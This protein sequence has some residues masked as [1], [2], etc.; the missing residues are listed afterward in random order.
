MPLFQ[1]RKADLLKTASTGGLL[2]LALTFLPGTMQAGTISYDLLLTPGSGSLYGGTGVVTIDTAPSP[3]T[4]ST[5]TQANGSLQS[6]S[7]YI[8]G[9]TFSLAGAS[10]SLVQFTD[11]TLTDI[12][13]SEQ[14]GA[15]PLR[16]DL[17][18]SGV[19]AFYYNNELSRSDGTFS[20]APA[21][22]ASPVPEPSSLFLFGTGVAGLLG[23]MRWRLS[24]H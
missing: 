4:V 19:Y 3:T 6:L 20:A 2:L 9:Q 17:Q 13:F 21:P 12:G 8:D 1:N 23:L 22:P 5:Y 14:T 24:T 10:G 18:T 16:F 7:F 11:G 15:D